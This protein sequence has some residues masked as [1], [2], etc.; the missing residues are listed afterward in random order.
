MKY[1]LDTDTCIWV[2]RRREP[3]LSRLNSEVPGEVAVSSMSEAELR[4]GALKADDRERDLA[5]VEAF[6]SGAIDALPFDRA[7]ARH[8]AEIRY[9]LR[10][11]PIGDRDLVIASV[12]RANGATL[13]TGNVREFGRVPGLG[14]EDW[15]VA[16]G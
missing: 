4:L 13:V 10:A 15:G 11:R 2:L 8:H 7:A 12:A 14:V 1:V 9:A 5:R 6:L 3:W 16:P